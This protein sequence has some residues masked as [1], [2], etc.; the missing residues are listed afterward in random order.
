MSTQQTSNNVFQVPPGMML[1]PIAQQTQPTVSQYQPPTLTHANS[2]KNNK[3]APP[4][5][6]QPHSILN[7]VFPA[8]CITF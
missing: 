7:P 6:V 1:V 2:F 5:S 8:P 4:P 3:V